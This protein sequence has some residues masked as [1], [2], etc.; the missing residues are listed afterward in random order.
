MAKTPPFSL[1]NEF[2]V[3]G[4]GASNAKDV[5]YDNT[6]SGL[7]TNNVN[8]AIDEINTKMS[9]I[10]TTKDW[11]QNDPKKAD[12]I[13]NRPFYED[14]TKVEQLKEKFIPDTIA[15]TEDVDKKMEEAEANVDAKIIDA[16]IK[17]AASGSLIS[18]PDSAE[19]PLQGMRIFGKTEQFTTTGKNLLPYPY[20]DGN[21]YVKNGLTLTVSNN[22]H[23]SVSGTA[24]A[25]TFFALVSTS[26]PISVNAGT[27]T[28]T[29]C[30]AGGADNKYMIS[31]G[32]KYVAESTERKIIKDFGNGQTI[33]FENDVYV[34]VLLGVDI[35]QTVSN[36][37]FKPMLRL[38]SITD[39][40]WEPYTGGMP[41]PNPSYPQA[42]ESVGDDGSVEQFVKGGNL[43][44]YPYKYSGT[45]TEAGV[46]WV[47]NADRSITVSGTC[48]SYTDFVLYDGVNIFPKKYTFVNIGLAN[49]SY[50]ATS[51]VYYG[52]DNK[53][54]V[55]F[56]KISHH[57]NSIDVDVTDITQEIT[58]VQVLLKRNNNGDTLNG[59]FYPAIVANSN[60][61]KYEPYKSQSLTIPTPN[62]LPGIPVSSGGNYTDENG[63]QWISDEVDL[64][65][66]VYVQRVGEWRYTG[67]SVEI[68]TCTTYQNYD[69]IYWNVKVP[70]VKAPSNGMGRVLS[71][72][73][74]SGKSVYNTPGYIMTAN[75]VA[76]Y[77]YMSLKTSDFGFVYG[78]GKGSEYKPAITN[79]MQTTFSEDNPLIALYELTEP[80]ETPLSE[81]EIASYKALHTNYPNTTIYN[82][83]G[84]Y[85]E[86]KYVADTKNYVDNKIATEVAKLTA[87][88]ITE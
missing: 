37:I 53:S 34:D 1:C 55:T 29:G 84:A 8:D 86:V 20:A 75:S 15:R 33:T 66:G 35:N 51:I 70:G 27:Y 30:P 4:G 36:L 60:D 28:V 78:D 71:N 47:E 26:N 61:I 65:R 44:P 74:L 40:T 72:V 56:S 18:L 80:I 69:V 64:E 57:G 85:T 49:T 73:F 10:D 7:E 67:G 31:L 23:V 25:R 45:K 16:S 76:N 39:D 32:Y 46:T 87:A 5:K 17:P 42:L 48:T 11:N 58:R 54:I 38:A 83:E 3:G 63:Q 50:V 88:I 68:N 82:D 6:S 43:L 81:E 14:G 62:G 2:C 77:L 19:A 13:K 21:K 41:S 59:T 9:D 22:G 52:I 79:W 24:T 12:Y